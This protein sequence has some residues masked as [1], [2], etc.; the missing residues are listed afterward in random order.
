AGS[1]GHGHLG[2]DDG[3]GVGDE[4]GSGDED[5]KSEREDLDTPDDPLLCTSAAG[6]GRQGQRSRSTRPRKVRSIWPSPVL[7]RSAAGRIRGPPT[8]TWS[9]TSSP[10]WPQVKVASRA[11][12]PTRSRN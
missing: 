3:P 11:P 1:R 7:S 4:Q 8:T 10:S 2:V 5:Q 6:C 9:V 12:S